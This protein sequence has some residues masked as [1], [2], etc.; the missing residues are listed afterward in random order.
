V[1][2]VAI[3]AG[4]VAFALLGSI[5]VGNSATGPNTIRTIGRNSFIRNALIQ[6]TYRFA[7]ERDFVQSGHVV[8]LK[9]TSAEPH[10]LTIV[11]RR[12]RP[13]NAREV[14]TCGVCRKYKPKNNVGRAGVN[15]IGDSRFV[16]P[17]QTVKF[18][19]TAPAGKKLYYLCAIHPWM[20]GSIT[21]R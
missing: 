4:T 8:V 15:R 1:R 5:G 3:L 18:R 7:P 10:T 19:V 11:P 2:R 14:F 16:A 13:S 6:S 12:Q 9:S 21:V 17:G 20:Q